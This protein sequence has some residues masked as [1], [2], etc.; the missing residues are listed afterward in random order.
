MCA[1]I[2]SLGYY[3]CSCQFPHPTSG[4]LHLDLDSVSDIRS[5]FE[6]VNIFFGRRLWRRLPLTQDIDCTSDSSHNSAP[7]SPDYFPDSFPDSPDCFPDCF[8][9]SSPDPSLDYSSTQSS[10]ESSIQSHRRSSSQLNTHPRAPASPHLLSCCW[11]WM[12]LRRC[13]WYCVGSR[14]AV[15]DS[16]FLF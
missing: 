11:R 8:P 16:D 3:T 1:R 7:D 12:W 15:A 13:F 14:S 6:S 10:T 2:S 4:E 5:Q 9:D